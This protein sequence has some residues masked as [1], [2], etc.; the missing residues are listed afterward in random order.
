[1]RPTLANQALV[2]GGVALVVGFRFQGIVLVPALVIAIVLQAGFCRDLGLLRRFAPTLVVL[3]IAS[4]LVAGLAYAGSTWTLVG[5]YGYVGRSGYALSPALHWIARHAGDVFLVVLGVP[6]IATLIL[7]LEA[8]R[9]RERDP[10]VCALLAVT[11]GYTAVVVVQVGVFASRWLGQLDERALISVAPPIFVAFAVWLHAGLPRPQPA[12]SIAALLAVA[13]ALFLPVKTAVNTF[14]VPSA[15]MVA[16]LLSLLEGTSADTLQLAWLLGAAGLVILTLFI[17]RRAAPV[18]VLLVVF[19]LAAAS[20]LVQKRIDRRAHGDRLLFFGSGS[21]DWIDRAA[22]GSAVYIDDE[23]PLWNAAWHI[24]FWNERVRI[25]ATLGPARG[26]LPGHVAVTVRPDGLLVGTDG[27]P[28]RE[29]LVVTRKWVTLVGRR[30]AHSAQG[31][32]EPGLTLWRTPSAPTVSTWTHGVAGRGDL[33][34]PAT[35]TVFDCGPGRLELTLAARQGL[36][37]VSFAVGKLQPVTVSLP[38]NSA[39]RGWIPVPPGSGRRGECVF[40]ITPDGPVELR[41]VVF[42]PGASAAAATASRR[43]ANGVTT[44]IQSGAT[45]LHRQESIGYCVSG[46]FEE[47]PA[48]RYPDATPATFV[49]G[50]GI[51]CDHPPD[52]YVNKGFATPDLGVPAHTYPLYGPP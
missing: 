9:G 44:F 48:G 29:R 52:G 43:E 13:P 7:A 15:F 21:P 5:A 2:G 50:Q 26:S 41:S 6:L 34:L 39:L 35:V 40:K 8:A 31:A 20:V 22:D 4:G 45:P 28:L 33:D 17:P 24:A 46:A 18:L 10:R 36:P 25:V 49:L 27:S 42:R 16:P 1:V 38:P 47:R 51:T 11:I 12:S 3:G 37:N 30:L 23:D 19:G 14:A 32:G